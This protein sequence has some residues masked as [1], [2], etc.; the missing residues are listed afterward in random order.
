MKTNRPLVRCLLLL[1]LAILNAPLSTTFAQSTAFT[2]QGRLNNGANPVTGIYDLVFA[3]CGTASNSVPNIAVTNT[4]VG[5]T[6][7]L[8]TASV[9]FGAAPNSFATRWLEISVRTN[10]GTGG[11]T[12]L[13][14]RQQL[15]ATPYAFVALTA[16]NLSGTLPVGQLTGSLPA[17]QL[18]GSIGN[19]QLANNAV[20]VNAGWGLAGGG[21]VP[22]GGAI[23]L[24]NGGVIAVTGNA[25]LTAVNNGGTVTLGD[26]ATNANAPGTLVKRDGA[27]GFQAQDLTLNGS[28]YL[29]ATTA[30][31]GIIYSGGTPLV[32]SY[33]TGNFFAGSGAGN[34]TTTGPGFNTGIGNQ[35][36]R[37]NA[38][39]L[40]NTASGAQALFGNISGANNTADG[41]WTLYSNTN[42]SGNTAVGSSALFNNLTGGFNTALGANALAI[43]AS[44][45][46]NI[47]IG[48]QAGGN[49]STN[50]NNID[51][52]SPGLAADNGII[53]LGTPG[54]QT[55][56]FIAGT[57]FGDGGGLTNVN[58]ATVRGLTIQQNTNGAP[59]VIEGSSANYVASGVAG[60]TIGG[61][62]A[63]NY[64]GLAFTN[65]VITSFGTVAGGAANTAGLY[66]T[67][68]GGSY[69]MAGGADSFVGG[70]QFNLTTGNWY[71]AI[72]G[73]LQNTNTGYAATIG[74]GFDNLVSGYC[75][76]VPGGFDNLAAGDNSFAAG[77]Q[78]WATNAGAF[79]WADTQATSFCSTTTNEFSIRAQNGLRLQADKGIHL[80][81]ADE[82][83]IVRDW[84]AF[85]ATAPASK[86]G[87][88]RWG[89][90]MEPTRL[91][92]GIPSNDVPNRYFQVAKYGTDGT[93]TTLLTVD[94]SGNLT[95]AGTL[96]AASLPANT[97]TNGPGSG[98]NSIAAGTGATATNAYSVAIANSTTASGLSST[99]IGDSSTAS[100]NWATALGEWSKATGTN[101][102]AVGA[103]ANAGGNNSLA[104]GFKANAAT[105]N[106][107]ALGNSTTASGLSSTAIG[108]SSTASGNWATALGEWSKAI[109]TNSAAVGA[110]ANA[111]GHYSLAAGYKA[112]AATNYAT[113][114]G[115][116]TAA[117]GVSSTALGDSANAS[118]NYAIA[119]GDSTIA[120]GIS[121]TAI[122]DNATAD[123]NW[124][125]S[126]GEWSSADGTNSTALG[127]DTTA[128]GSY[129]TALG[130]GTTA[131][132]KYS[133]ALGYA[134]TASSDNATAL[135]TLSQA[136]RLGALVWSD[137]STASGASAIANNSV[138]MRAAGGYYLYSNSGM[139][140]GVSLAAGATAWSTLSDQNAKKNF[141]AVDGAAVLEKLA[142]VPVQ[143]WNY[144][145]ESDASTPNI[146]PMAQA[147]KAAFYPG[148]DDKRITTLEFDGVELAAIQGLNE[149]LE[150]ENQKSEGQIAELKAE[151]AELKARLTKLEQ[152]MVEKIGG[153]K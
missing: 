138:T 86:A 107:T 113:A 65:S 3:I 117:S 126:L 4:A 25:D 14:P 78:A 50:S 105:N 11:F 52:G 44:G 84:D 145:W 64:Y 127:P 77:S 18:S 20:T 15:T 125:T 26:T 112:N 135:G 139:T 31:A 46:G 36:L 61:G 21:T 133:S 111:G 75:A 33:G 140:A 100:G 22:L 35:A 115:N 134:S 110:S 28:L 54:A 108:D 142:A 152:L 114:L 99:A 90:F 80:N 73:G 7:G 8:F 56:A 103:S 1:A 94:Q 98:V 97:L 106:A 5:V 88:G 96:S 93:A 118:S 47:A 109:G 45:S 83:L 48:F 81:A 130:A 51:I 23:T 121:S 102:A 41:S 146:G 42:G 89:L 136:N 92:I 148:R 58:A 9:D 116:S 32:L 63:T 151:N 85:A 29:P 43:C 6:N 129:S 13:A 95:L 72:G 69:N 122:G 101:S 124:S 37:A 150:A 68:C 66:A 132:G 71:A 153:V 39:G 60:A 19:T 59:N 147:F 87:I 104:A 12:T 79:V 49:L 143:K 10:G 30:G 82:P 67:V 144:K 76:T 16:S 119:L 149:K 120:S 17:S 2:Y 123:G 57:I 53:R 62:G 131:S 34:V 141:A 27:G 24:N 91:T 128:S 40:G 137:A 55:N 74:G 70:G 38:G